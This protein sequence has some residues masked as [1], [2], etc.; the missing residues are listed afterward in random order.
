M[1]NRQQRRITHVIT[2]KEKHSFEC[3]DW[4]SNYAHLDPQSVRS[5]RGKKNV[6]LVLLPNATQSIRQ[7]RLKETQTPVYLPNQLAM[8]R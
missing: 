1:K 6:L 7:Y 3:F 5:I 4:G 2:Q 8:L